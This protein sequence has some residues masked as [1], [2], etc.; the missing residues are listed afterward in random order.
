MT[1]VYRKLL[2]VVLVVLTHLYLLAYLLTAGRP[3]A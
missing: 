1:K 2:L 3:A